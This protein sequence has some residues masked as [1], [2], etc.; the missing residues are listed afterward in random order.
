M[1]KKEIMKRVNDLIYCLC[2]C[3]DMEFIDEC[4]QRITFDEPFT[5]EDIGKLLEE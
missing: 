1:S 5:E 2:A 3:E 4:I